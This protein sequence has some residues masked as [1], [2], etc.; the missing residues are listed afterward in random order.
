MEALAIIFVF[1]VAA[2]IFVVTWIGVA[3]SPRDVMAERDQL[4]AYRDAL[5]KKA[6]RA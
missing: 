4:E 6:L 3:N 2:I 5:H 1:V